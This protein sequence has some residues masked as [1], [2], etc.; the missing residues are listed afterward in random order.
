MS[1]G[2][3]PLAT[4]FSGV[5]DKIEEKPGAAARA[6]WTA[7]ADDGAPHLPSF[8]FTAPLGDRSG[9]YVLL[10]DATPTG[11]KQLSTAPLAEDSLDEDCATDLGRVIHEG[12]GD[13]DLTPGRGTLLIRLRS[14][15]SHLSRLH[16]ILPLIIAAEHSNAVISSKTSLACSLPNQGC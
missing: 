8:D 9:L 12:F 11:H 13:M 14:P 5:A 3:Q 6:Q 1:K 4:A 7:T 16:V 10:I 2:D 15:H